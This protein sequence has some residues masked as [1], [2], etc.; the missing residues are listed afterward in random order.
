MG[1]QAILAKQAANDAVTNDAAIMK[2]MQIIIKSYEDA[3]SQLTVLKL[4]TVA[5][6]EEFMALA[7][8]YSVRAKTLQRVLQ[9]VS[10]AVPSAPAMS[11]AERDAAK[12]LMVTTCFAWQ[13]LLEMQ[14]LAP[15]L[16][17][18]NTIDRSTQSAARE[19]GEHARCEG[20]SFS[21]ISCVFLVIGECFARHVTFCHARLLFSLKK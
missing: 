6:S 17:E 10:A 20:D 3:S 1:T 16:M 13:A 19:G 9:E 4:S 14:H 15:A 8:S 12:I 11:T 21:V 18:V 5:G 2:Q 7:E